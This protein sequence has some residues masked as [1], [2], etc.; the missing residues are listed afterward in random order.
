[1]KLD[2]FSEDRL[3]ITEEILSVFVRRGCDLLAMEME[4]YHT[5]VSLAV[6]RLDFPALRQDILAIDGIAGVVEVSWLPTER[7]QMHLQ[8][9]LAKFP[10]AVL[11]IDNDGKILVTNDVARM[12]LA[13]DEKSLELRN[14]REF[15][16]LT[17]KELQKGETVDEVMLDNGTYQLDCMPVTA[18]AQ[19]GGSVLILRSHRQVGKQLSNVQGQGETNFADIIGQSL[20]IKTLKAQAQRFAQLDLPVL[21]RGE[22]GTGK[23]LVARA[24]H[25]NSPRKAKPFLA[26]NCATL[27]ENLLESELFGYDSGAFTG[28]QKRGKPG[29]FELADQGTVFLDEIGEMSVYLQAKLLRFL[30]D[31]S[32]RRIGGTREVKVDVRIV[33]ATHRSLE[34]MTDDGRFRED[35]FYRLNVLNLEVPPLR[36]RRE[37]I[38]LLVEWFL[39]RAG[40]QV[41]TS[42]KAIDQ[43]TMARIAQAPWPGNVRQLQNAVFRA[44]ALD[45]YL[46]FETMEFSGSA[47]PKTDVEVDGAG[48][49]ELDLLDSVTSLD[50]AVQAYECSI[51]GQLYQQY[52]STRKLAQRLGVS[53]AKIAR[54]LSYYGLSNKT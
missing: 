16:P 2:I 54:K 34:V 24:L 44:V 28:A 32:F 43:D 39:D 22:T 11:N 41:N 1:M 51:L 26:I 19:S 40:Q 36:E 6:T 18:G 7:K 47:Q 48:V 5:Y 21:I 14:I 13:P 15:L 12:A 25:F 29:L 37:D 17:Y 53:H 50:D 23:E 33:C 49:S 35:L 9:V 52:P 8:T 20:K 27:A 4:R 46:I 10:E 45:D 31:Y 42:V 3:G 30:Q 38:P